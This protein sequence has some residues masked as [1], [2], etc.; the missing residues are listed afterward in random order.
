MGRESCNDVFYN[1]LVDRRQSD[2]RRGF[3]S[4]GP[5]RDD[6][7]CLLNG[8]SA[9]SYGS[10]GQCRSLGLSLRLSALC[11]IETSRGE[12]PII[13]V[14]DAFADLDERRTAKIEELI[15]GRGQLFVTALTRSSRFAA[16]MPSYQLAGGTIS[17]T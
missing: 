1:V 16:T 15:V 4:V 10:R 7:D 11:H 17:A 3:C 12:S 6:F 14:D 9:K 5:H 2:I 13:L 8:H